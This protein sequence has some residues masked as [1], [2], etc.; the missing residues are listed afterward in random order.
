[1]TQIRLKISEFELH[2]GVTHLKPFMNFE[3]LFFNSKLVKF[4][5]F[6]DKSQQLKQLFI[7]RKVN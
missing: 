4:K 6:I 7:K 3:F 5:I 2:F 1:M